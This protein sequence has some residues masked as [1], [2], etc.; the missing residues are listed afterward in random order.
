MSTEVRLFAAAAAA[1]GTTELSTAA[2][3][4]SALQLELLAAHPGLEPVLV[5]CSFLVDGRTVR[6]GDPALA[7]VET[8]DVLPP[9]AG[10]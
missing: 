1:A 10:G 8:V 5:R 3:T 2:P 4:L 6:Q 7:G 9:F